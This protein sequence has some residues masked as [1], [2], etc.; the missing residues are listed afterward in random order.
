[1]KNANNAKATFLIISY[2]PSTRKSAE[3]NLE[4]Q[5]RTQSNNKKVAMTNVFSILPA[6]SLLKS[7]SRLDQVGT[8]LQDHQRHGLS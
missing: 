7:E 6:F 8:R 3:Q 1:M 2:F 4:P 5:R